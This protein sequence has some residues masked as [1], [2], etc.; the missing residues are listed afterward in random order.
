MNYWEIFVIG[1]GL[2]MDA[3]A[4]SLCKGMSLKKMSLKGALA[5][6][7][8]F[9]GFQALMPLLGWLL[10]ASFARYVETFGHWIAFILLALVGGSMIRDALLDERKRNAEEENADAGVSADFGPRAMLPL[11][12]ATSIDAFA[13]GV[14]FSF[15]DV[16][17]YKAIAIIGCTTFV[18]S[19]AG[20]RIGMLFGERWSAKAEIAGGCLLILIGGILCM[21]GIF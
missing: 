2:A 8:Y 3:F 15:F 1:V 14:S 7:L 6:G 13:V 19:A 11:A 5:A 21:R 17:I 16:N 12:I 4:V 9:G 18:I 20:V 10:G